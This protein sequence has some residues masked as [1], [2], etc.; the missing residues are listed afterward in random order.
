MVFESL[1]ISPHGI[2]GSGTDEVGEFDFEG[3]LNNDQVYF[4]K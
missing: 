3:E 2:E 1:Q 4:I